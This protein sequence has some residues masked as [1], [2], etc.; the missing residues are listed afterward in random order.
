MGF[1]NFA[2]QAADGI[3]VLLAKMLAVKGGGTNLIPAGSTYDFN[4]HYNVN[5]Q[6]GHTYRAVLVAPNDV[7]VSDQNNVYGN[8][9]GTYTFTPVSNP[10]VFGGSGAFVAVT[11][12]LYFVS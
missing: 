5:I 7:S 3:R 9:A 6:I 11:A 10:L 4:Q 8:G 2:P 12:Q 1:S